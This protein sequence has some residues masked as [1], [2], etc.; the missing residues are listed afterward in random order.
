MILF[1]VTCSIHSL[2]TGYTETI[3]YSP[4]FF[5]S[6]FNLS[7]TFIIVLSLCVSVFMCCDVLGLKLKLYIFYGFNLKVILI[8]CFVLS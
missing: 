7:H 8:H 2:L 1:Y 4:F 3:L 6:Q 5:N